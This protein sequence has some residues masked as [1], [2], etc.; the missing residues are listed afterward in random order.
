MIDLKLLQTNFELVEQSIKNRGSSTD[1]ASD[2]VRLSKESKDLKKTYEDLRFE[3]KSM[4]KSRPDE[5]MIER[6]KKLKQEVVIAEQAMREAQLALEQKA[7]EVPNILDPSV[8]Y[9]KDENDNVEIQKVLDVPNFDFTPLPHDELGVKLGWLDFETAAKMSA[10][11]FVVLR[12]MGA[13]LERALINYMLDFNAKN[14]FE[15]LWLP[16]IVNAKSLQNTGQ[17]PKFGDDLF[18]LGNNLHL[19]PTAEVPLVNYHAGQILQDLPIKFCAYTSCFRKEAGSAGKDTKGMMRQHQFDKVELVSF[20]SPDKSDEMFDFMVKTASD[21]LSSLGLAHRLV[22]L[23]SG[24]IGFG[25]RKT[26]DLEV[27]IPSQNKYREISSISNMGDFQSRRSLI[28]YKEDGKNTLVHTLNGSSLAVGR[29]L[30][31]IMENFQTKDGDIVIPQVLEK[32]I[33]G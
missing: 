15:E 21:L 31:A 10:S 4:S 29:T 27:W 23:C 25:A 13:K 26:I 6:Q 16:T 1:L 22:L 18:S 20:C 30:I 5:A 33:H 19:I 11:R 8:P 24:D 12:K 17:L 9:G 32:Y 2:L 7:L 3:Q 14:G 28:R